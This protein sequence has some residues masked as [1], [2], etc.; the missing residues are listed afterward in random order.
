MK[1]IALSYVCLWARKVSFF[2]FLKDA[3]EGRSVR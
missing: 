3:F 2:Q 1:N